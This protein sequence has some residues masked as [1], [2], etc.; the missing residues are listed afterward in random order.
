MGNPSTISLYGRIS[1]YG[2]LNT[3]Q[4]VIIPV[5]EWLQNGYDYKMVML[6]LIRAGLGNSDSRLS[7]FP[8]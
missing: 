3:N 4:I 6:A 2:L 7:G 5:R 8:A 1:P